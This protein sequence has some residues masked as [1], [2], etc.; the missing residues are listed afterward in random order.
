VNH[1]P[2]SN[3]RG[4]Y[5]AVT[6]Y[7][8]TNRWIEYNDDMVQ[9][10]KFNGRVNNYSA[11]SFQR[12]V[13]ML[14][15]EVV[16][17]QSI[18]HGELRT[19][20]GPDPLTQLN[21]NEMTP[22]NGSLQDG[23]INDNVGN[24][25]DNVKRNVGHSQNVGESIENHSDVNVNEVSQ[26]NSVDSSLFRDNS[27]NINDNNETNNMNISGISNGYEIRNYNDNSSVNSNDISSA[28][29]DNRNY[30]RNE[31]INESK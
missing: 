14:F 2:N 21:N 7:Q 20:I 18:D 3:D 29:E 19:T 4:H 28:D 16:R 22:T 15:Y 23:R 10:I 11:I 27:D 26:A 30:T 17:N 24:L 25:S 1:N 5:T 12:K 13:S 9:P 6:K 31:N 8:R